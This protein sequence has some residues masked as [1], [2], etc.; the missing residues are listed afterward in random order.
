MKSVTIRS[1][2]QLFNIPELTEEILQADHSVKAAGVFKVL[3]PENLRS[4]GTPL[5]ELLDLSDERM[6]IAEKQTF[7]KFNHC[8]NLYGHRSAGSDMNAYCSPDEVTAFLE[9]VRM[10]E[11]YNLGSCCCTV[12]DEGGA[13]C[14]VDHYF[15]N[16][17]PD[18]ACCTT[19]ESK[20]SAKSLQAQ[21]KRDAAQMKKFLTGLNTMPLAERL[22][23][24]EKALE[25]DKRP[26]NEACECKGCFTDNDVF[27]QPQ[28]GVMYGKGVEISVSDRIKMTKH[29]G[30]FCLSSTSI[31]RLLKHNFPG[32]T[33]PFLYYGSTHSFFP[34]HIEDFSLFSWNI[35]HY[36]QPKIWIVVPPSY[37]L[38]VTLCIME[39]S[40]ILGHS[41]CMNLLGHKYFMPSPQWLKDKGIPF[42]VVV[43]TEGQSVVVAP[44]AVHFGFNTGFNVA[45]A[46]N[47]ATTSWVPYGIVAPKCACLGGEVHMELTRLVAAVRP[48]LLQCY[49]EMSVPKGEDAFFYNTILRV[50][51]KNVHSQEKTPSQIS[52]SEDD[53]TD[54]DDPAE[55]KVYPDLPKKRRG[56]KVVT[57][58]KVTC[59][60]TYKYGSKQ[61]LLRHIKN[62]HSSDKDY[63]LTMKKFNSLFPPRDK[64]PKK[65][66]PVD[67]CCAM[68]AGRAAQMKRHLKSVHKLGVAVV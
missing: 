24:L 7:I 51:E 42:K 36:G 28:L 16:I 65:P 10:A 34:A 29:F 49:L 67:D 64:V 60:T 52:C 18:M 32:I 33:L 2:E 3:L 17:I 61:K 8:P 53:N 19:V 11:S 46:C 66:C 41:S 48:D 40:P 1:E 37:A 55:P 63:K 9:K 58:T 13:E 15:N 47:F 50:N 59:S 27:Q 39:Q 44:N 23:H 68:I 4:E 57:C 35:L 6:S 26:V 21:G 22:V 20:K 62:K 43:Q 12:L 5:Q 38:Q 31:L 14:L 45:E 25:A 54:G 30:L 56:R